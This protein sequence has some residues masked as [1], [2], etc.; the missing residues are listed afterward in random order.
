MKSLK[1][2]NR[3][4]TN[5]LGMSVSGVTLEVQN[6]EYE[7]MTLQ[8]GDHFVRTRLAKKLLL[9]KVTLLYVGKKI[10]KIKINRLR[11]KIV[12]SD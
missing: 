9:S 11:S 6:S 1:I 7:G 5:V 10:V 4:E 3:V 12:Q 2:I 8:L